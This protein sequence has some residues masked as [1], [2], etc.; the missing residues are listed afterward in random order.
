MAVIEKRGVR[1]WRALVRK[2]GFPAYSRTFLRQS[3]ANAWATDVEAAIGRR[4]LSRVRMLTGDGDELG[5][6]VAALV[7]RYVTEVLPLRRQAR[8]EH[9]RLQRIRSAFGPLSLAL[10]TPSD[11]ARW[12][13]ARLREG[14]SAGTC[15]H[16]P[17]RVSWRPVGLSQAAMATCSARCR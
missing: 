11:V 8:S 16:E 15:R 4:D 7:D 1:R 14:A 3:D 17:A 13:D 10:V 2:R 6:T 9:P 5:G 12:R